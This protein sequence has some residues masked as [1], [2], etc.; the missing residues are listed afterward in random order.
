MWSTYEL[1]M[2]LVNKIYIF[3]SKLMLWVV[4]PP[5]QLGS[6]IGA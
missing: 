1:E 6:D 2:N 3:W 5:L 4:P